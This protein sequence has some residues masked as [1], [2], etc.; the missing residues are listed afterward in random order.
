[1][2]GT[3]HE[4]GLVLGKGKVDGSIPFGSTIPFKDLA[5][6]KDILPGSRS[7]SVEEYLARGGTITVLPTGTAM[8]G[9]SPHQSTGT[10]APSDLAGVSYADAVKA[11]FD[12]AKRQAREKAYLAK[13][14]RGRE[15]SIA[16]SKR[17]AAERVRRLVNGYNAGTSIEDLARADGA[18]VKRIRELL[19]KAGVDLGHR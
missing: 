19:R 16:T 15:R 2:S 17:K 5:S 13:T 18:Q 3:Q 7:G 10:M 1:M 6:G 4:A 8:H 14:N 12:M 9:Y 11:F